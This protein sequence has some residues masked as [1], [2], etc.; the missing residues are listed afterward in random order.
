MTFQIENNEGSIP[1]KRQTCT[2][3]AYAPDGNRRAHL[4]SWQMTTQYVSDQLFPTQTDQPLT[5]NNSKFQE[6]LLRQY[7]TPNLCLDHT[8]SALS[9]NVS[10]DIPAASIRQ[11]STARSRDLGLYRLLS[12]E[13]ISNF[14]E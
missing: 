13:S 4:D 7:V 1:K 6:T 9:E 2:P 8:K 11:S 14:R 10:S 12:V 5:E 3:S